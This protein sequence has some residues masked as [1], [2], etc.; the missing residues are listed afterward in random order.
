M[1]GFVGD[2]IGGVVDVIGSVAEFVIDNALPIISTVALNYFAPGLGSF[3]SISETAV[4]AIGGAAISALNGGSIASIATA[5]LMPFI[6]A[7]GFFEKLGLPL[8]LR[9]IC[10]SYEID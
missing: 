6:S 10:I 4:K 9:P 3:F 5:G 2:I 1:C 8:P 7:P